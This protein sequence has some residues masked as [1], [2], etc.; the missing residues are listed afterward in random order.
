MKVIFTSDVENIGRKGEIKEVAN[1][2]ARNF[3]IPK[4]LAIRATDANLKSWEY[5]L[6]AIKEK[7]KKNLEDAREIAESMKD[8]SISI[9]MK[10]GEENKLFGSVTSQNISD[11]LKE[12]GFDVDKKDIVL[13]E[14]IKSLGNYSIPVKLHPEVLLNISLEVIK[15]E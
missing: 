7:D 4:K 6:N 3:L 8:V 1:G 9:S 13:N 10:A 12:K 11:S 2:L 15:E 5:R 14:S